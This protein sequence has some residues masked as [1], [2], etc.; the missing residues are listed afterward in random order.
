M[1]EAQ[2]FVEVGRAGPLVA[3]SAG[4]ADIVWNRGREATAV[5]P[6][7]GPGVVPLVAHGEGPGA[8]GL[9]NQAHKLAGAIGGKVGD[10]GVV[11]GFSFRGIVDGG[12]TRVWVQR[13]VRTR[14]TA[15]WEPGVDSE[16]G[17]RVKAVGGSDVCGVNVALSQLVQ[18]VDASIGAVL[19]TWWPI[20]V[21]RDCGCGR[22]GRR[23]KA[24]GC[25]H[26]IIKE[27]VGDIGIST[28]KGKH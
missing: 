7:V 9:A 17:Q 14:G 28:E 16:V 24:F 27:C 11:G 15:G 21:A 4:Y 2:L 10:V 23:A 20:L 8:R 13:A 6:V 12:L 18:I 19:C 3:A 26:I 22:C 5:A 25:V 1:F